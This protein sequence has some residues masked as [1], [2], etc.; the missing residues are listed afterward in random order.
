VPPTPTTRRALS[1]RAIDRAVRT[2]AITMREDGSLQIA[3]H[4]SPRIRDLLE[5]AGLRTERED[6]VGIAGHLYIEDEERGPSGRFFRQ[7]AERVALAKVEEAWNKAG[8]PKS[9]VGLPVGE[10]IEVRSTRNGYEAAFRSGKIFVR[11]NDATL[12]AST[13]V[14]LLFVG[15]ECN[16]KQEKADEIYGVV[17]CGAASRNEIKTVRFPGGDG[18]IEMGPDGERIWTTA[19]EIYKGPLADLFVACTLVENDSG[20]VDAISKEIAAKIAEAAGALIGGLTGVPAESVQNNTWFQEGIGKAV[21]LVLDDVMGIGDDP[22]NM[23]TKRLDWSELRGIAAGSS[24]VRRDDDAKTIDKQNVKVT[25][26]QEDDGGDLG[27]YT[28]YFLLV[29]AEPDPPR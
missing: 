11:G 5:Q 6:R 10:R 7:V 19:S 9:A 27:R 24:T 21:G 16:V 28:F 4:I 18:T 8:G 20:D 26:E 1:K 17:A 14:Q 13:W 15:V 2:G 22:Y 23:Q 25:L 29:E 3:Q 12:A